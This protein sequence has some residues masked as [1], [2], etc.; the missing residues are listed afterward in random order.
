M[1]ESADLPLHRATNPARKVCASSLSDNLFLIAFKN[2]LA[3]RFFLIPSNSFDFRPCR[4][5]TLHLP[6][7]PPSAA[8]VAP[9]RG[10]G[11]ALTSQHRFT[12]FGS[13]NSRVVH[14]KS[15]GGRV[16]GT[17]P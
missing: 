12:S 7:P 13:E 9:H 2:T 4:H 5:K 10:R 11:T 16:P 1:G 17:S 6:E 14:A 15:G 8:R 3:E